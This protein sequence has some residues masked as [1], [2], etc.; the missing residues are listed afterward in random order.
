VT[1]YTDEEFETLARAWRRAAQQ[2]VVPWL[3]AP[4]FI[5]WLKQNDYI[6]DYVRVPDREL[7]GAKGK[8]EP[9]EGRL[10]FRNSVWDGALEGNPHGIFTLVHEASHAILGHRETRLRVAAP[11][12][13][14]R[15]RDVARDETSAN[16]LTAA[17]LAPFDLAEFAPGCAATEISK[18]FG[19]SAPAAETRLREFE[20][21]YRRRHGIPRPLPPGVVDFLRAQKGKGRPITHSSIGDFPAEPRSYEGDACP[22]CCEFKMVRTGLGM[23]CDS[24]GAITGDD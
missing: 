10:Y 9:D 23:K 2:D 15:K 16:R 5:K 4:R 12:Y 14:G 22:R 21:I 3:D 13:R 11:Q 1:E 18:R 17:L 20:R 7:S 8:Y 6:K 24:C 19:L